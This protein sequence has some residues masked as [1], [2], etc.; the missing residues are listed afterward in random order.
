VVNG[1]GMIVG[2]G[3]DII[4]VALMRRRLSEFDNGFKGNIFTPN[5]ISYCDSKR[6]PE[7][8]YAA[9]FAAK[10]AL[11]KALAL[12]KVDGMKWLDVEVARY[13]GGQPYLVLSGKTRE[14]V[15]R[16]SAGRV[17]VTLSHTEN[18]GMANVIL[19]SAKDVD[20]NKG[21]M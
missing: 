1:Y 20:V 7:R 14:L 17:L 10:E 21:I 12:G 8:H 6:Y 13:P 5:E 4:E 3:G 19:E 11:F 9:R 2:I 16:S 15:E 18:W